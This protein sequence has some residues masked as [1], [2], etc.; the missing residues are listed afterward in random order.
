MP[1]VSLGVREQIILEVRTR[2]TPEA[3]ISPEHLP[4]RF[5]LHG[6]HL[7]EGAVIQATPN[8]Q[9]GLHIPGKLAEVLIASG[10]QH[11]K[12]SL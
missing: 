2:R 6:L 9:L 12:L 5:A 8:L 3:D 11:S 7:P 4:A 10:P 1:E